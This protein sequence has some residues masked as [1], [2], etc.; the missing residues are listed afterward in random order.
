MT[1]FK[2]VRG[3]NSLTEDPNHNQMS[4]PRSNQLVPVSVIAYKS[5]DLFIYSLFRYG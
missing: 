4:M 3:R 1:L 2:S 5:L